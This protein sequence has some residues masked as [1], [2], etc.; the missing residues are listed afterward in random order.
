M[1]RRSLEM[2][3]CPIFLPKN[4]TREVHPMNGPL[5]VEMSC[6]QSNFGFGCS[7]FETSPL[8]CVDVSPERGASNEGARFNAAS[9]Y[10]DED[11]DAE[12]SCH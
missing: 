11:P 6:R 3:A 9:T 10:R 8:A 7:R 4:E 5:N 2:D 12:N 1:S